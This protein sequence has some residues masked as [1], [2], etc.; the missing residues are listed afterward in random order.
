MRNFTVDS[1]IEVAK[2]NPAVNIM[3]RNQDVC[4]LVVEED[5]P[6]IS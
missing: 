2:S 4:R 1:V 5:F 6:G 3:F